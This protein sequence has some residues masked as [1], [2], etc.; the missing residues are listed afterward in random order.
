M[1]IAV[2]IQEEMGLLLGFAVLGF[3]VLP[4]FLIFLEG[5]PGNN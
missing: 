3:V 1:Q 5:E 2:V 4:L